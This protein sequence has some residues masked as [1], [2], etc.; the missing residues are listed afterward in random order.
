MPLH[1]LHIFL[2]VAE[3]PHQCYAQVLGDGDAVLVRL[4]LHCIDYFPW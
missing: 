4:L 1:F 2:L 3:M